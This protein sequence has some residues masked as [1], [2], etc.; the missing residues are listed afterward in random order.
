MVVEI[1]VVTV[2]CGKLPSSQLSD[3]THTC[4]VISQENP[5]EVVNPNPAFDPPLILPIN[6]SYSIIARER[7]N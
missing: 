7:L 5:G 4:V 2:H 3:Q 6:E 1:N